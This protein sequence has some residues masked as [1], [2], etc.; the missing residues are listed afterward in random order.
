MNLLDRDLF[1]IWRWVLAIACTVYATVITVRWLWSWIVYLGEPVRERTLMRRYITLHLLRM[2]G[3]RFRA[4]LIRI[5][6]YSA[7]IIVVY[8]LHEH[9]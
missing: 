6:A 9:V 4:E 8:W 3:D 2:R 1:E 7:A 5:V